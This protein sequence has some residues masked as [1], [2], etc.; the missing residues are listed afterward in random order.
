MAMDLTF[1][2]ACKIV[3]NEYPEL[4]TNIDAFSSLILVSGVAIAA[5]PIATATGLAV[6][7]P[8]TIVLTAI[9]T[10]S[11]LFGIKNEVP[12]MFGPIISKITNK[13]SQD[14]HDQFARMQRAYTLICYTAFFD[15]LLHDKQ[16][17]PLL[18]KIKLSEEEKRQML[19]CTVRDLFGEA[20]NVTGDVD[21]NFLRFEI[22]LPYPGDTFKTQRECLLPLYQKLA[23]LIGKFFEMD[24]VRDKV[25]AMG[26][27]AKIEDIL[28]KLPE[29]GWESFRDQY[30]ALAAKFP[31]FAIW[32][33]QQK[34]DKII[35]LEEQSL[36]LLK[37]SLQIEQRQT[38]AVLCS[39]ANHYTSIVDAPIID[40]PGSELMY[41]KKRDIFIRQS[42]KVTHYKNAEQLKD[43]FWEDLPERH[44]L[45]NFLC[46]YFNH[47]ESS[48]RT[49]LI[50][51]GQPGSGKSLLTSMIAARHISLPFTSIRVELR[52]TNAEDPISAQIE[53]QIKRD[54]ERSLDWITLRDHTADSPIL[55]IFDGYD[56]LLQATGNIFS[57]YLNE[58]KAFQR[59]QL[60]NSNG[61]QSVR[62]VVTSRFTLID[63]AI[64]PPGSTIIRLLEFDEEQQN[65]WINIWNRTNASYF[66]QSHTK[67]FQLLQGH[68]N[69]QKLAVQPLLLMMLA[70][71][72]SEGNPLHKATGDLD[73]SL[74]YDRLLRRFIKRELE[75]NE[76]NA[77]SWQLDEIDGAIDYE[78]KRLGG[79]AIGMFN[80]RRLYIRS[81]ELNVDL[82]F[83]DLE[84]SSLEVAGREHRMAIGQARR[85]LLASEKVF[86]SF[87]FQRLESV[88][89]TE[90]AIEDRKIAGG[91][92]DIAYE[93]LHN[94]F[95]EFLTADFMLR[96]ILEETE[97]I[98]DQINKRAAKSKKNF[99][100]EPLKIEL[101]AF[102]KTWYA[103]FMYAP[104]FSR[105]IIIS[106]LREWS[107]HCIPNAGR[108]LDEFLADFDAIVINHINLLLT[109]NTLPPLMLSD[110]QPFSSLPAIG[111]LA[112]YT[113]NLILLRTIF[114][115]NGYTFDETMSFE[116]EDGTR[117]WD[118]LTYLWR[119]WFS[120][121]T[122]NGLV[123]I[124]DAER[125]D[126]KII[127]KIKKDFDLTS[128]VDRF[129]QVLRVSQA[130]ADNITGGLAS[131]LEHDAF[132][133]S[134]SELDDIEKRLKAEHLDQYLHD[135][136]L[137]KRLR[138]L[139]RE[140]NIDPQNAVEL[141]GDRHN[142]TNLENST[143]LFAEIA[144]IAQ[145]ITDNQG[146][147]I[148][149][150][151]RSI[152]FIRNDGILPIEQ[153]RFAIV[154]NSPFIIEHLIKQLNSYIISNS[155]KYQNLLVEI[156]QFI[157]QRDYQPIPECFRLEQLQK[158]IQDQGYL[159]LALAAIMI[160][161]AQD[162]GNLEMID[163]IYDYYTKHM[164]DF[165]APMSVN[166]AIELI[167]VAREKGD[168]NVRDYFVNYLLIRLRGGNDV[169]IEL[170]IEVIRLVREIR[171]EQSLAEFIANYM[172][173]VMIA[174]RRLP[175]RM[176]VEL[177][178]TLQGIN[179]QQ[180]IQK[181]V[182]DYFIPYI[183]KMNVPNMPQELAI[184]I[185]KLARKINDLAILNHFSHDYLKN[186]LN[187][188]MLVSI[189][190][191]VEL[192]K[193]AQEMGINDQ[194]D[195]ANFYHKNITPGRCH[196]G[197]LPLDVVIDLRRLAR[198][199]GDDALSRKI[200]EKLEI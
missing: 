182:S 178:R 161:L 142:L 154:V 63:K 140:N 153:F 37:E 115:P 82:N 43:N 155:P 92:D 85:P 124:F 50:I 71:Y 96:S 44:D 57:G 21:E 4:G 106:L 128:G 179:D 117:A 90:E 123:A 196:L 93:F 10:L 138:H 9:G 56:E 7:T 122:L 36:L 54:T 148:T 166:L 40:D 118:R 103:L 67:P 81:E 41:P 73:Q 164:A 5:I 46:A 169:P 111:Y 150:D 100:N 16:L 13:R 69:I 25:Q 60:T 129:L 62:A 64:I 151:I 95:G 116:S 39:L 2:E 198:A 33:N 8:A 131:L 139:R 75:K 191:A 31:E 200:D 84:V 158:L 51:L 133:D 79:A 189:E 186:A 72:D 105:P 141:F 48:T 66:Q 20:R 68:K 42:F 30:T 65:R 135:Y 146:I 190:L 112:I 160:E 19:S 109:D 61:Q 52:H 89:R 159:S 193:L 126:T 168:W 195:V 18:K 74:L 136:L 147:E 76:E 163:F 194:V 17:A 172:Q 26:G 86:G 183:G 24:I 23:E 125:N 14:P 55:V 134:Q 35:Q 87:F 156:A 88:R 175:L 47:E 192:L 119:S 27:K 197:L 77:R 145:D 78:M 180:A 29:K 70:I 187:I 108:N 32:L 181:L 98:R 174:E 59:L 173:A 144:R 185:I 53:G 1:E 49:P 130:L 99:R 152:S 114:D 102:D 149:G 176:L 28:A 132:G 127:L 3:K 177:F 184:Q 170:T 143:I 11:N 199:F 104:L 34:D 167:K 94:T 165:D 120:L 121:E 91:A 188:Q 12:K 110:Q 83:F 162:T 80:R 58:V 6:L 22:D 157:H 101:A 15:M 107:S 45:E 38:N 171:D 97:S 137:T 113:L